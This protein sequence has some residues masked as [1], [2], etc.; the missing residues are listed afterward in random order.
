MP[1]S[2]KNKTFLIIILCA[3]VLEIC[4]LFSWRAGLLSKWWQAITQKRAGDCLILEKKYCGQGKEVINPNMKL[5]GFNLPAD[6]YVFAPFDGEFTAS[7]TAFSDPKFKTRGELKHFL[8]LKKEPTAGKP[9]VILYFFGEFEP[10][11]ETRVQVKK[12]EKLARLNGVVTDEVN[13]LTLRLGMGGLTPEGVGYR[14][15]A[16]LG[17]FFSLNN[18][19]ANLP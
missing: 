1:P 13:N 3:I 14:D 8:Q 5:L 12:G 6:T 11:V 19:P 4:L 18:K 7:G 10:L 17:S 16:I 2:N 9:G 15:N